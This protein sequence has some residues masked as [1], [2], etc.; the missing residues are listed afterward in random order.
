MRKR[1]EIRDDAGGRIAIELVEQ[2]AQRRVG[3]DLLLGHAAEAGEDGVVAGIE[4]GHSVA[5][6]HQLLDE[7]ARQPRLT[8]HRVPVDQDVDAAGRDG[9]WP[10]VSTAQQGGCGGGTRSVVR[11]DN[12]R[13]V[14]LEISPGTASYHPVAAP[15][16]NPGASGFEGGLS[17]SSLIYCPD[18]HN[19]DSPRGLPRGAHG[20]RL[21]PILD[22]GYQLEDPSPESAD[23]YAL[24]YKC[25]RRA[26]LLANQAGRFPHAAHL[27]SAQAPCAACHDAHGSGRNP[28]LVNF[29]LRDTTGK[30][31]VGPS[32]NQGRL[33]YLTP[34]PGGGSG[35]GQCF[36][37][38][39]GQNHEPF[40]YG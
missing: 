10:E 31:V 11:L 35:S 19:T 5:P 17:A 3:S 33:E 34:R 26:A 28:H 39:H 27:L 21:A 9:H 24:C 1:R 8:R 36:L 38:C 4:D 13:N 12:T 2:P 15:G 6:R 7:G 40:S 18:C 37:Q 25:H 20:S 30:P 22:R 29:M 23:A 32:L 16:R 14:R